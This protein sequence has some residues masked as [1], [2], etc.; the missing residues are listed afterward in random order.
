MVLSNGNKRT[1]YFSK[2]MISNKLKTIFLISIPIFVAHGLE[3][4]F[5]H[6]YNVD[7]YFKFVFKPF[8]TMSVP[9]ASFLIFQIML[10]MLLFI[11]F[12]LILNE[13]WRLRLM[14][15]PGIVYLL[16]LHHVWKALAIGGYYPGVI[17]AI[18]FPIIAFVFWKE[19]L[20]NYK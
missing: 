17:T 19:L 11:S 3:E 20:K 14:V 12:L 6:F 16:E 18:A 15:I 5:N 8:E 7:S 13:K 9:Q 2:T 4:Y 1:F 10:W